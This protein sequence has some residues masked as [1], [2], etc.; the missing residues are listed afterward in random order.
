MG[1]I[2]DAVAFEFNPRFAD[3][4]AQ[5]KKQRN[6]PCT[7]PKSPLYKMTQSS[8]WFDYEKNLICQAECKRRLATTLRL[9]EP[10]IL[11]NIEAVPRLSL[12]PGAMALSTEFPNVRFI[13][14]GNASLDQ[15]M[16]LEH[17]AT[18]NGD[19]T[20]SIFASCQLGERLPHA[21]FVKKLIQLGQIEPSQTLYVSHIPEHLAAARTGGFRTLL[22]K[23]EAQCTSS[24]RNLCSN[25]AERGLS[26]LRGHS[27][28]LDLHTSTGKALK[29][30][31]C[32]LL[33]MDALE[34]K[35]LVYL[36]R[37]PPPFNW[38]YDNGIRDMPVY[39]KPACVDVNSLGL[40]ILKDVTV[41]QRNEVMEQMLRLRDS[42]GI[43]QVYFS[44]ELIRQDVCIA[45]NALSLFYEFGRGG[46]L[47]KTE[48]WIFNTLQTRA[49][50]YS[51]HYYTTPDLVLFFVSRLLL[52]APALRRR[53][54]TL[55][56]DCVLERKAAAV[57]SLSLAA[58]LIAAARCGIRDDDAV[59]ELII[60]QEYDGSW[61]AGAI[62]KSPQSG[63]LC[64]HQGVTTA[65]AIQAIKEQGE[66]AHNKP[67]I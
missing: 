16:S 39:S 35:D 53:F 40:S 63:D 6:E 38:L 9:S 31:Y 29:D 7:M 20:I 43:M 34:D 59:S 5:E 22:Y 57:D 17:R 51:S 60:R 49:H 32:Q 44:T 61:P 50:E 18:G 45:I 14:V 1:L 2:V 25:P 23:N 26:F 66:M 64:Y 58:R 37:G 47:R 19:Q 42:A 30:V 62:Y 48:D 4:D 27:G 52:K 3:A 11:H 67:N 15:I 55:L 10:E 24:V 54:G 41:D 21:G 8:A 33:I 12:Q 65:W 56:Y 36:P 13:A 28:E 46:K